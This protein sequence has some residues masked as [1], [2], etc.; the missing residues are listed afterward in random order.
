MKSSGEISVD[1]GQENE[2]S[3][4]D[5]EDEE[6]DEDEDDIIQQGNNHQVLN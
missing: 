2:L 5:E 6:S 1:G 4:Q 3:V